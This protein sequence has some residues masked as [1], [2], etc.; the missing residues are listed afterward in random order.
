M[1]DFKAYIRD[2]EIMCDGSDEKVELFNEFLEEM[3]EATDMALCDCKSSDK[4]REVVKNYF[5]DY[6]DD[7]MEMFEDNGGT[8]DCEI[9]V[10]VLIQNSV[11]RKLGRYMDMQD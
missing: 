9:G 2:D 8:C 10:S 6:E 3:Q 7:I 5:P 1:G 4:V 11:I